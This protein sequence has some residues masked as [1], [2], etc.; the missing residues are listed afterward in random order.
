MKR[1]SG[2]QELLYLVVFFIPRL[3]LL[4]PSRETMYISK[5]HKF[6]VQSGTTFTSTRSSINIPRI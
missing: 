2:Y 3:S 4:Q 1:L 6:A 5:A